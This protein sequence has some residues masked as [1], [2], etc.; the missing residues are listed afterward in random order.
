MNR[1][2]MAQV[3]VVGDAASGPG[4]HLRRARCNMESH[5]ELAAAVVE[6][7]HEGIVPW[8]FPINVMPEL[9]PTFGKFFTGDPLTEVEA[10][11]SELDSIIKATGVK[12]KHHWNCRKPRYHRLH[13]R[14][15]MPLQSYF[16][17]VA[18]Y[19]GTLIH[20]VLHHVEHRVGWIGSDHQAEMSAEIGT[21]FIES[22][23]RLPHDQENSNIQKWLPRW[24]MEM[25]SDSAYLFDAVAQAERAVNYLLGLRQKKEAA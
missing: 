13:D 21:G 25:P 1:K 18:H 4:H 17:T 20:E 11:Y 8:R 2:N 16:Q 19:R 7:L 3:M 6:A 9:A 5:R 24:A 12:V 23:L 22:F 14:I 10:D 15:V